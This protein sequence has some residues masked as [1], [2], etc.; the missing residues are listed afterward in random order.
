MQPMTY[1]RGSAAGSTEAANVQ[2]SWA[3]RPVELSE[4]AGRMGR[5]RRGP[6][7][8]GLDGQRF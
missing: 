1:S 4:L 2:L 5:P 3:F 7:E 8:P 6:V